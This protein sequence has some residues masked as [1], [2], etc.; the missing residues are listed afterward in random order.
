M[1]PLSAESM[2]EPHAS[3][4][5]DAALRDAA[6][7]LRERVE[8]LYEAAQGAQPDRALARRALIDGEMACE[9]AKRAIGLAADP[10][11]WGAPRK[12]KS[13]P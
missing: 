2:I 13:R 7:R 9:I 5:P 10:T 6:R 3:R 11:P 4:S 8:G 12:A 1:I